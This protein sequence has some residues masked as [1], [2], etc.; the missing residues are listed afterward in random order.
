VIEARL[1]SLWDGL[2]GSAALIAIIVLAL[3]VMVSVVKLGDLPRHL[4]VIVSIVILLIMLPA[5]ILGLWNAMSFGQHLGIIVI[6]A[7]I[8]LVAGSTCRRPTN[9]RQK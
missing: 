3:C 1:L 8:M 6:C 5:I 4:G 9:A 7:A 2:V